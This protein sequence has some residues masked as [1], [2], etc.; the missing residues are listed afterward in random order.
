MEKSKVI[1]MKED[2][3][4]FT[5]LGYTFTRFDKMKQNRYTSLL[6]NS[7]NRLLVVPSKDKFIALKRKIKEVIIKHQNS[8]AITLIKNL[9]PILREWALYFC[10]GTTSQILG[11]IDAY[12]YN[13]LMNWMKKKYPKTSISKLITTYFGRSSLP[14]SMTYSPYGLQWHFHSILKNPSCKV[15]WLVRC[16]HINN[17]IPVGYYALSKE[18]LKISPY[19][20]PDVYSNRKKEKIRRYSKK[21]TITRI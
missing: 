18:I 3:A 21:R 16:A 1:N 6:D 20:T 12:V 4:K 13:R 11:S 17:R 5:F 7:N 2:K 10:L 15:L 14:E 9:N 8:D 19:L